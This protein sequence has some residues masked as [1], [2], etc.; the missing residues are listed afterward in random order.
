MLPTSGA[1]ANTKIKILVACGPGPVG[2]QIEICLNWFNIVRKNESP[3]LI[4]DAE[5]TGKICGMIY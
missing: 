5:E 2:Q 1:L 3:I 4:T